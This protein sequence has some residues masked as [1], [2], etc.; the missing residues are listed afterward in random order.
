LPSAYFVLFKKRIDMR[1]VF[2]IGS[3]A[4]ILGLFILGDHYSPKWYYV[5]AAISPFIILG[6]YDIF[7]TKRAILRNYPVVGHLRYLLESIRPEIGQYFIESDL[8][9]RPFNRRERSLV[10]Q[11]AKKVRETVP[12]GTQLDIHAEGYQWIQ[13]SIYPKHFKE[14]D[15]RVMVGNSQCKQP[16]SASILNVSAMSFGSLSKNAILAL[17]K[18]AV[19]GDFAHNTGE[20]GVSPHHLAPGG[21]LIWQIGTGYFGCRTDDGNFSPELYKEEATRPE[22]KMIELKL[23]QG[24]KPGHGGILPGKK[25]TPEIARIRKVKAGET[26]HSPSSHK[27]FSDAEG[28]LKF[29]QEL[30]DLSGGKPVGFKLCIGKKEEFTRICDA[31]KSTGILPDFIAVDGAEGGTGAAP[32]EFSDHI[33]TPMYEGLSFVDNEL[34]AHGLRQDIKIIASGRIITG[35]DVVK[36]MALGA[37]ICASARGMMLAL[38]CIQALLCH[39]DSCP[40]GVATQNKALMRGLDPTNKGVRVGNFQD[41]TVKAAVEILEACGLSSFDELN[42][43]HICTKWNGKEVTFADMYPY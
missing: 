22:V 5:L 16:Y 36:A 17:N 13:H 28:M 39:A 23:S 6:F 35:F 42:R 24:A 43:H 19:L 4:L 18:G 32:L 26:I 7:Q 20:G 37:D 38:G 12:F 8:S 30:R 10:Y 31:M 40:T 11:R 25:N 27:A 33:G 14:G 1:K 34:K 41:G 29:V 9:G 21:D 3:L 2:I 15:P